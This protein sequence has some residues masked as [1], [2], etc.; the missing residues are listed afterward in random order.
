MQKL[1]HANGNL[2]EQIKNLIIELNVVQTALDGNPDDAILRDEEA[3][4]LSAFNEAKLDEERYLK[5]K[6]KID[7]LD[8]GDS[9]FTYFH[10]TIKSKNSRSRIDVLLDSNNNE[11]TGASVSEAFVSHYES[12]LGISAECELLETK[13]L[14]VKTIPDPLSTNMIRPITNDEVRRAM[15]HT[16]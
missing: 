4:Y 13:G 1:V 14:F 6:A 7:W 12:F 3:V 11:I 5:Q 10:K 16:S 2:H 9:N 8:V 15:C